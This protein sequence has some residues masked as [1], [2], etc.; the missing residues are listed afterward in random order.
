ME[1]CSWSEEDLAKL[2]GGNLIRVWKEVEAVRDSLQNEDPIEELID[3]RDIGEEN[4]GC[5]ASLNGNDNENDKPSL[6]ILVQL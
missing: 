2:A 1:S 5:Y 4:L 6:K 3:Q